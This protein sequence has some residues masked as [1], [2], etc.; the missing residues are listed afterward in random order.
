MNR[1]S[2]AA[3]QTFWGYL[4]CRIV[5]ADER[6][7]RIVISLD[8]KPHHL[9]LLGIIHGGVLSSLLDN[10]MGLAVMLARPEEKA[11]TT[12]LNVHFV[13]S[14]REGTLLVTAE[15]VHQ[16]RRMITCT[17]SIHG[18]GGQLTA[19]GTGSFRVI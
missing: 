19:M 7:G 2:A 14:L 8:V 12:N 6:A 9:N 15:V 16:S 11:V 10:A 17:G 1:L 13:S 18:D 4:G 5:S 3:E